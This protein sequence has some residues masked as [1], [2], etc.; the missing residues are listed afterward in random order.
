MYIGLVM[1]M[2][3]NL[4]GLLRSHSR[5]PWKMNSFHEARVRSSHTG[6]KI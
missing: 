4:G 1:N 5:W 6:A 3:V 2:V